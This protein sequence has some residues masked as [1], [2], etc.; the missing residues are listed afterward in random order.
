MEDVLIV[1]GYNVIFAWPQLAK[2]AAGN[3]ED[4]RIKLLDILQNFQGY[5]G[6]EVIVVFDAHR[7]K[8]NPG[9]REQYGNLL[10][11]YT[12]EDETADTVIERLVPACFSKGNVFV[13]TSDWDE[14]RVVFGQGAYRIPARELWEMVSRQ[15]LEVAAKAAVNPVERKELAQFLDEETRRELEKWRRKR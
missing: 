5:Q 13:V 4:A 2:L 6:N 11:I 10:V 15:R 9:K 14:Q 1:D 8:G 12:A 3:F 7:V